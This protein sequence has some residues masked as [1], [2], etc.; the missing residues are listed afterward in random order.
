MPFPG[1]F[2]PLVAFIPVCLRRDGRARSMRFTRPVSDAPSQ[3]CS[4]PLR[5]VLLA[6]MATA[7]AECSQDFAD[8]NRGAYDLAQE[9]TA[10]PC[11]ARGE[12][13]TVR[14]ESGGSERAKTG[15]RESPHRA[16]VARR[17]SATMQPA[18]DGVPTRLRPKIRPRYDEPDRWTPY[19]RTLRRDGRDRDRPSQPRLRRRP[20]VR[21]VGG[22]S[23]HL[24]S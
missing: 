17:C 2:Q 20:R 12:P 11:Q 16:S 21:L 9:Q 24:Q 19:S 7:D 18:C 6:L 22:C 1:R 3:S 5:V 8:G 13:L 15:R 14:S 10:F 4:S 23:R